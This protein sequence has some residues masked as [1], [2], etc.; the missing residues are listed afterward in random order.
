[1]ISK[2]I[3]QYT[4]YVLGNPF[5]FGSELPGGMKVVRGRSVGLGDQTK[6]S[7][8]GSAAGSEDLKVALRRDKLW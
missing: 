7:K 4:K 3:L 8:V 6:H 1:M 2:Y 5:N